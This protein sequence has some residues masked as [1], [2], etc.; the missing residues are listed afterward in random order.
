MLPTLLL[1]PLIWQPTRRVPLALPVAAFACVATSWGACDA[2]R[3]PV[4]GGVLDPNEPLVLRFGFETPAADHPS[5][6]RNIEILD[7]DGTSV[8]L[9]FV[10]GIK[11]CPQGGLRPDTRYTFVVRPFDE[12]SDNTYRASF[13]SPGPTSFST[14]SSSSLPPITSLRECREA[15]ILGE[16]PPCTTGIPGDTG[17][18]D[19]GMRDSGL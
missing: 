4:D 19:S 7:P 11:I 12:P 13:P 17:S 15:Q 14:L 10:D 5:V 1:T 2:A 8:P 3:Y 16:L 9:W 18:F 6:A